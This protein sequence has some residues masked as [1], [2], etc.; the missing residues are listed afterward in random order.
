MHWAEA[1]RLAAGIV[2]DSLTFF[3]GLIL[4]RDAV[5]RLKDLKKKRTDE[6]FC[7][8]F[9]GLNLTDDEWKEATTS[10]R[11]AVA[12]CALLGAGFFL[13]LVVRILELGGQSG[14]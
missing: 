3:G 2:A 6:E 7:R 4:T 14:S 10:V 11:W 9:S 8:R 12:G 5:L 13:Q 1:H